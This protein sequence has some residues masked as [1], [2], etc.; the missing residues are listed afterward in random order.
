M[1][2]A[3]DYLLARLSE[4]STWKG[5]IGVLTGAGV[6]IEPNK[7]AAIIAIGMAVIGAINVFRNEQKSVDAAVQRA[8]KT[9]GTSLDSP[10]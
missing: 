10:K 9:N 2:T 3:I 4:Q 1:K 5:I 8:I 6:I 7:A